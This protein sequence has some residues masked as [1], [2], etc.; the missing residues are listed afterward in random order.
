ML[1]CKVRTGINHRHVQFGYIYHILNDKYQQHSIVRIE[2][3]KYC[4]K[5]LSNPGRA[6]LFLYK[7][8][9]E[10]HPSPQHASSATAFLGTLPSAGFSPYTVTLV[11]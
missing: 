7:D 5:P 1:I 4:R 2:S 11:I 6:A 9:Y 3:L 10:Q 8:P